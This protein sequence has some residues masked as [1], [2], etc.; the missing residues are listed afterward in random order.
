MS[1]SKRERSLILTSVKSSRD[2]KMRSNEI[3]VFELIIQ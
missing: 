3:L 2:S 1:I